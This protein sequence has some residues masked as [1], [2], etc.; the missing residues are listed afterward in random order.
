MTDFA[1]L[2][3]ATPNCRGCNSFTLVETLDLGILA[4]AGRFVE[5]NQSVDEDRLCLA[6]CSEC[7]LTQLS[8]QI[9]VSELYVQGYGYESSLNSSMAAHLQNKARSLEETHLKG[10]ER[11]IVDIAS[12]DGTLLSGYLN[13]N[14][15]FIGIDPLISAF[16]DKYPTSATKI[17]SFFNA[18]A[19]FEK[20]G[21]PADLVTSCS[22]LYDSD[23]P[24]NFV[25]DVAKIL[26]PGGI[27]HSEQSY[28]PT[29]VSNLSYD[30]ICH[31]HLLYLRLTD[32]KDWCAES[33]LN[34][35]SVEFND[36]NGGSFA[37]TAQKCY[38]GEGLAKL[39]SQ[40]SQILENE[41]KAGFDQTLV[42]LRDFETAVAGHIKAFRMEIERIKSN[43]FEIYGLGAS[44]KGNIL[45]QTIGLTSQEIV[46][47]GDV[48]PK[49]HGL[50]TPKTGIPIIS[51]EA[52]VSSANE[53]AVFI[54]LPWHFKR[55]IIKS[56]KHK[57]PNRRFKLLFPLP[58]V[59][60]IEII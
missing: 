32:I 22:V 51:E 21:R 13:P 1:D 48:N 29:M 26:A 55:S 20:V 44:T 47:I 34:L 4:S 54:V 31:E 53:D 28:L 8:S 37:F 25:R 56:L 40:I 39:P 24:R 41:I 49:K 23:D 38:S 12:N 33:Q 35:V 16:N 9:S 30:T 15:K 17:E 27:W 58:I 60:Y 14:S 36:I 3:K 19:Y 7:G 46:A 45:L 59:E 50:F 18:E 6:S 2:K 5:K 43:G 57:Y 42:A 10:N 11:I 52:M